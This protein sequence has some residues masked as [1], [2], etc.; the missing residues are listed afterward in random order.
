VIRDRA[1]SRRY[2]AALF[3]AAVQAGAAEAILADLQSLEELHA[4]DASLQTFLEAPDVLTEV[5]GRVVRDVLEGRVHEL[6]ARLLEL[7]LAKKRVQHLP[8]VYQDYREMVEEHLGVARARV[9]TAVPLAAELAERLRERLQRV[10]GLQVRLELRR[11]PA[12]LGGMIVVVG[13]RILDGSL[14]HRLE[15]V[16]EHLL[17]A[18]VV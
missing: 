6:V 18:R 7:M 17:G 13:G 1:V 9:V 8:L 16:R 14:R 12:V 11:D 10:T 2:A 3:G 15:E 5:K 4:R